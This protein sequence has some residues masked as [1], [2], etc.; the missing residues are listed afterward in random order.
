MAG[1]I[2]DIK[3]ATL[4]QGSILNELLLCARY[5]VQKQRGEPQ[6]YASH[7]TPTSNCSLTSERKAASSLPAC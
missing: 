4:V 7:R 5:H 2:N 1:T 6:P 3:E